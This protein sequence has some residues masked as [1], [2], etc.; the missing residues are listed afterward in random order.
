[1]LQSSEAPH[2]T[3]TTGTIYNQDWDKDIAKEGISHAA[4]RPEM[5]SGPPRAEL[6]WADLAPGGM[7]QEVQGS[8]WTSAG[9][10]QATPMLWEMPGTQVRLCAQKNTQ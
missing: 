2:F 3:G 4:L 8:L 10:I 7:S 6:G 9:G 1:M 5:S